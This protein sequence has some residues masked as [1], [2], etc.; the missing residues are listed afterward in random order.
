MSPSFRYWTEPPRSAR[1]HVELVVGLVVHE[2]ERVGLAVEVLH[3]ALVDDRER[4]L[5]VGTERAV[6]HRTARDLLQLRADERAALARLHV[7]ELDH[8]DQP[9]LREVEGHAVLE[10]VGGD[11]HRTSS[12]GNAVRGSEPPGVTTTVSSMRT[13]PTPG[14]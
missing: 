1:L 5:L 13:P 7:L 14:R 6:D 3:L 11:A 4:D 2:D 8:G 12:F 9:L 10:I